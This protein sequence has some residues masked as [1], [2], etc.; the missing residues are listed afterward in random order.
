MIPKAQLAQE[1]NKPVKVLVQDDQYWAEQK[2]DG[3]RI[4]LRVFNNK[5]SVFNRQGNQM[6]LKNLALTK[7][8]EEEFKGMWWFDGEYLNDHYYVFDLLHVKDTDISICPYSERRERLEKIA[9]LINS[10]AMTILPVAKTEDDKARL[11][12]LTKENN[13]EGLVFKEISKPY[14]PGKNNWFKCKHYSTLDA[15]VIEINRGGKE[16]AVTLGLYDDNKKEVEVGG[17]KI[18]EWYMKQIKVGSVIEVKYLYATESDH[19]YIPVFS[20]IRLDKQA[21]QC[22]TSQ[23][24]HT[25]K[26]V[27]KGI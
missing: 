15:F 8:L 13:Y 27:I 12:K 22:Y 24:Q 21:S 26:Q 3:Q 5:V 1:S 14:L 7:P 23:L 10:P 20:Q 18:P 6:G 9:L 2:V 11:F 19:L 16:L 17:C 4:L 25:N